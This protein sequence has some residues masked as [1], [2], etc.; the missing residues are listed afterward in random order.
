MCSQALHG[1]AK[2]A[3]H[4]GDTEEAVAYL[5]LAVEAAPNSA[6]LRTELR[7]LEEE[8]DQRPPPAPDR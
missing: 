1:M 7:N 4:E 2:I 5:Q 8:L 3:V 6:R